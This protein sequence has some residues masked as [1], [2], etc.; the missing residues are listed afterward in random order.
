MSGVQINGLADEEKKHMIY[1][2]DSSKKKKKK[3]SVLDLITG[4]I[5]D[6]ES[7]SAITLDKITSHLRKIETIPDNEPINLFIHTLG[8]CAIACEFL[9][10]ALLNHP[11][12]VR[13]FVPQY[14]FSAG[15]MIA[16]AADEL[17]MSKNAALGPVD[18]QA[19][20][21]PLNSI[22]DSLR[23]NEEKKGFVASFIK[24]HVT[25]VK[26]DYDR[27]LTKVMKAKFGDDFNQEL[28]NHFNEDHHHGY[29]IDV[30]E[31]R[32]LNIEVHDI[33]VKWRD[34][35]N[36]LE[37]NIEIPNQIEAENDGEGSN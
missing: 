30:P 17:Y 18:T 9:V 15:T 36:V 12:L 37:C 13:V 16:L 11:G 2:V 6:S 33:N 35:T 3:T 14:A 21:L 29:Q 32:N 8:G 10:R 24:S 7:T 34:P 19:M 22:V 5:T 27:T 1:L 4:N 31:L 26:E 23:D 25:K 28:M 20:S